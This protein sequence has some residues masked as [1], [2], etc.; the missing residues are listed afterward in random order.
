MDSR[1]NTIHDLAKRV[2]TVT[3]AHVYASI[4]LAYSGSRGLWTVVVSNAAF[5]L[6]SISHASLDEAIHRAT[7]N[8]P[9]S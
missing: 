1:R 8:L 2:Q 9:T 3:G 5:E 4:R 6:V 7:E